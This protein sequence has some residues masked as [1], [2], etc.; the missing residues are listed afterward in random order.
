[1]PFA[2]LK[3]F[4]VF[5]FTFILLNLNCTRFWSNS[6]KFCYS[7][8]IQEASPFKKLITSLFFPFENGRYLLFSSLLDI[9][10]FVSTKYDI[11]TLNFYLN[12][13]AISIHVTVLKFFYVILEPCNYSEIHTLIFYLNPSFFDI[14]F[15][16][17][18]TMLVLFSNNSNVC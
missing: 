4:T 7:S 2:F 12:H 16:V 6:Y 8:S 10:N 1:M 14:F 15:Y 5:I 3:K 11:L 9:S 13:L 18:L 17:G